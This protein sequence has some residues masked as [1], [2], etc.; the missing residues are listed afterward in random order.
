MALRGRYTMVTAKRELLEAW[1]EVDVKE[2]KYPDSIVLVQW[3]ECWTDSHGLNHRTVSTFIHTQV[4]KLSH[5]LHEAVLAVLG[6][7]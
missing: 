6:A 4:T 3:I 5:A 7:R 2:F 1:K